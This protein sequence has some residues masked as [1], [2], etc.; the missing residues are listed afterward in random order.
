VLVGLG[1]LKMSELLPAFPT[2]I[3]IYHIDANYDDILGVVKKYTSSPN[4]LLEDSKSSFDQNTNLLLDSDLLFLRKEIL[5]H[6]NHYTNSTG[7][8]ELE[9]AG[10]WYNKMELGKKVKQHRHEGSVISG[11]FYIDVDEETVPILFHSPLKPYKMNDLYERFDNQYASSGIK[12]NPKLGTLFLFPSWLEHETDAEVSSRCVIS[13]NT[14]Y[15]SM[16]FSES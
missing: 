10:S 9:I 1:K 5:T 8:Q 7:L 15:K 3:G 16:F 12:L 4:D 6:V 13:F 11:A 14:F 2:P